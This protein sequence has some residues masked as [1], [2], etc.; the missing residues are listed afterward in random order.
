MIRIGLTRWF[1]SVERAPQRGGRVLL[2][3]ELCPQ[4]R[5][6]VV[7]AAEWKGIHRSIER[8]FVS[9][10]QFRMVQELDNADMMS[11][12]YI[13][14]AAWSS[15]AQEVATEAVS[16]CL[17]LG[18]VD[19]DEFPRQEAEYLVVA[20]AMKAVESGLSDTIEMVDNINLVADMEAM[21]NDRE[22]RRAE[23][24]RLAEEAWL[25]HRDEM[26]R[27]SAFAKEG[28]E[29]SMKTLYGYLTEAEAKEARE[30]G[31]VTVRLPIG[32]FIVPVTG[33]G[34][35]RQYVDGKYKMS[36]CV[37]FLDYSLPIGDEVL[38]KI[39]LLKADPKKLMNVANKFVEHHGRRTL[40]D[41]V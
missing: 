13:E 40:V 36:Y 14:V 20:A 16:E 5:E 17:R 37:V 22:V 35:I 15:L 33:H 39:I 34:L 27:R 25:A 29:T 18:L 10:H 7:S 12:R 28:H 21:R 1:V 23:A 11:S 32:D 6:Y 31:R 3:L 38:M 26:G 4:A 19:F 30:K 24:R 9:P 2:G 41:A 8:K